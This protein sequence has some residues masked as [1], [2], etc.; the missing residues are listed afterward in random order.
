M[1]INQDIIR[2]TANLAH[3]ELTDEE[4]SLYVTQLGA[5]L[6]YVSQLGKVPTEGVKPLVTATDM[7]FSFRSDEI[8]KNPNPESTT[9]NSPDKLGNLFK[10]PPVL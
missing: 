5:I 1:A 7:E 2:K 3:L 8:V 6:D 10:V 4:V 9:Q